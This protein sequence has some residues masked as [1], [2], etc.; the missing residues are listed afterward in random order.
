MATASQAAVTDDGTEARASV[1]R[2]IE[3]L[4][5]FADPDGRLKRREDR[6]AVGWLMIVEWASTDGGLLTRT[7]GDARGEV[8]PEWREDGFLFNALHRPWP[9]AEGDQ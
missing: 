3:D 6:I 9:S 4:S 2:F 1:T 7:S 5:L 8:L